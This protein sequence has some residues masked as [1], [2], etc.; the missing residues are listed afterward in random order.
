MCY[1]TALAT[2]VRR[3]VLLMVAQSQRLVLQRRFSPVLV[4]HI[5]SFVGPWREILMTNLISLNRRPCRVWQMHSTQR[6]LALTRS[7]SRIAVVVVVVVMSV[8]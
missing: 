6:L 7:N 3:L 2:E 8:V 5:L 1:G 4:Q